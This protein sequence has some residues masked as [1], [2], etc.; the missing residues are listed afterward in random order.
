VLAGNLDATR[1]RL[2]KFCITK[3][4]CGMKTH[5]CQGGWLA[6]PP[7]LRPV[8]FSHSIM[9]G[10][11]VLPKSNLGVV[12]IAAFSI[13]VLLTPFYTAWSRTCWRQEL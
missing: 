9:I 5:L 6:S 13:A 8:M 11:Y 4:R 7:F 10:M 12:S 1:N 3:A 2:G